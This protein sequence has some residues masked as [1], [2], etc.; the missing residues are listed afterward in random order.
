VEG[1][2][3]QETGGVLDRDQARHYLRTVDVDELAS[4]AD[5][6]LDLLAGCV[7]PAAIDY[8]ELLACLDSA[9]PGPVAHHEA[10]ADRIL[11][12]VRPAPAGVTLTPEE[13]ALAASALRNRANELRYRARINPVDVAVMGTDTDA[14]RALAARLEAT[15]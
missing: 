13:A 12:L 5:G 7:R 2:V 9:Y 10:V 1:D 15:Q 4:G 14:L 6:V 8:E 11:A 3:T